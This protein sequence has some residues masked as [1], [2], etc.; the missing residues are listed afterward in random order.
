M[1]LLSFLTEIGDALIKQSVSDMGPTWDITRMVNYHHGLGRLTLTPPAGADPTQM[2]GTVFLQTYRLADSSLCLKANLSWQGSEQFSTITV[3]AKPGL[4]WRTETA[5][6]ASAWLAGPP[7]SCV[8]VGESSFSA[9]DGG[10]ERLV[11][12]AN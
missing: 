11:A 3:Y 2:R 6:I 4:K 7:A 8:T 5:Q 10:L 9:D 12:A 1:Q